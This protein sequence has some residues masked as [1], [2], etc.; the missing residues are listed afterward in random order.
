MLEL[1]LNSRTFTRH[2]EPHMER[3]L[4]CMLKVGPKVCADNPRAT[5]E[6]TAVLL[7]IVGIGG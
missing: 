4:G 3:L 5:K 1:D 7:D 2:I 6:Q